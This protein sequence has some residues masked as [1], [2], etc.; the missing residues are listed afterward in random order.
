MNYINPFSDYG[1]IVHDERFIGRK[2]EMAIIQNRLLGSNFGNLAI[3]GLPR[4]GKSS[5]AH[6]AIYTL[7]EE[8]KKNR[9]FVF[10]INIGAITSSKYFF[11]KL[12]F[13]TYFA[14]Q[15]VLEE[16]DKGSFE[17]IYKKLSIPDLNEIEF[18]S[19]LQNFFRTIKFKDFKLIFILDEF[20]NSE[21]IFRVEDFQ[22]LRELSNDPSTQLALL[23]ISRRTLQEL[24]PENGSLSNFYQIFSDL[25]LGF[26][27][28]VDLLLYWDFV[29]KHNAVVGNDT[30]RK[31]EY[32]TSAHPFMLDVINNEIFNN[33]QGHDFNFEN[34]FCSI[35][36][37]LRLK[38][39]NEYETILKLM[40]EERLASKLI[41]II[42]GPVYDVRQ[43]DVEK[44]Q[45]Y[46]LIKVSG[47][48]YKG[49]CPYFTDFLRITQN[50]IDVWP[51]W[52]ETE[53]ELRSLIKEFLFEKYGENW[54]EK[55]VAGNLKQRDNIER[56]K[57]I[58]AKNIKSFG[59]KASSHLVDYTYPLEMFDCF[60]NSDWSWF[61]PIFGKQ[62]NDWKPK[63]ELL[64]EIRNPLAHN[65]KGFLSS[66][67]LNIATG[68][69]QEIISLIQK[70]KTNFQQ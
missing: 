67:K 42:V 40:K 14:I 64:S 65:N 44:L 31:I 37:N 1:K 51:L 3:M 30:V 41:Q 21:R 32:Y 20:D 60:I 53:Y 61:K 6:N 50:E 35:I 25:N 54:V 27:N 62:F 24:E 59:D 29:K 15:E 34:I 69:C 55:F 39:L 43:L 4:I 19:Y 12:A 33:F 57:V 68:F 26:F 48:L 36:D 18:N 11:L 10:W 7:R 38:I 46:Q 63:F 52:S 16:Q 58:M 8:L 17:K 47:E 49:F 56:F 70:R 45:K 28:D 5:L 66:S 9:T 2:K 23:T 13:D 22:L